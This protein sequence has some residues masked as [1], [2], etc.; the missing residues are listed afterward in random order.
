MRCLL[1]EGT[2]FLSFDPE[3]SGIHWRRLSA[4]QPQFADLTRQVENPWS[5]GWKGRHAGACMQIAAR[6]VRGSG[7]GEK[8]R[9]AY[10]YG[11]KGSRD[12]SQIE[13]GQL[14]AKMCK[15]IGC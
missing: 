13:Q 8:Q 10:A 1:P 15:S 4:L 6:V 7:T 11:Y 5:D 12:P 14:F 2:S 9:G 3:F